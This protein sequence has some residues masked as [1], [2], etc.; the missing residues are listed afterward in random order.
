MTASLIEE[1]KGDGGWNGFHG[2]VVPVLIGQRF[3]E[4]VLGTWGLIL[5]TRPPKNCYKDPEVAPI[6]AYF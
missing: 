2:Y 4:V 1:D 3:W 6:V 5:G